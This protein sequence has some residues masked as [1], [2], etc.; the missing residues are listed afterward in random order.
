MGA[1]NTDKTVL[2]ASR[3]FPGFITQILILCAVLALRIFI[4]RKNITAVLCVRH[5]DGIDIAFH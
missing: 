1:M 2:K 4:A 3:P 5:C